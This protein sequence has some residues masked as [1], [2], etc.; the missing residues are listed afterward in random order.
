M[1]SGPEGVSWL[2][3]RCTCGQRLCRG[4]PICALKPAIPEHGR[5]CSIDS[6]NDGD[7]I[8]SAVLNDG[9]ALTLLHQR[10][11]LVHEDTRATLLAHPELFGVSPAALTSGYVR[12]VIRD[13][14][15]VAFAT[16]IPR[17]DGAGE[18]EDLFVDPD[19]MRQGLGSAL[20]AD[21]IS[22]ARE[23]GLHR[24]EVT[25]NPNVLAFYRRVGFV[26]DGEMPTQFGMGP[27]MHLDL[28]DTIAR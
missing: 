10:S 16:L 13:A 26:A 27:R 9:Q 19:S 15:I 18:L 24:I 11:S 4:D 2:L 14:E 6:V 1:L 17:A 23:R 28:G 8:R 5:A 3:R 25:A 22:I 21:T 7:A 12:L 20:M